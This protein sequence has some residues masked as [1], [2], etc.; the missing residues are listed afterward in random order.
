[1]DLYQHRNPH[2]LLSWTR[3]ARYLD[4]AFEFK[5]LT[6]GLDSPDPLPEKI[7]YDYELTGLKLGY[8]HLLDPAPPAAAPAL[9]VVP[10]GPPAV[11]I[12]GASVPASRLPSNFAA[13]PAPR[14]DAWSRWARQMRQQSGYG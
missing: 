11:I 3:M 4:L 9:P 6:L 8:A 13:M 10:V 1:M 5:K 2:A 12:G 14:C 7:T